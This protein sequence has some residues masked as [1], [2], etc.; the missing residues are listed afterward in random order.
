MD[1]FK[2][3][4]RYALDSPVLAPDFFGFAVRGAFGSTLKK[5][6]CTKHN[7]KSCKNCSLI[8]NCAYGYLYETGKQDP[9]EIK[10]IP[11]TKPYLFRN[12]YL[13]E[14]QLSFELLIFTKRALR[15]SSVLEIALKSL[16]KIGARKNFGYGKIH[17]QSFTKQKITLPEKY[18]LR[19]RLRLTFL[20]PTQIIKEYSLRVQPTLE[21]IIMN[22]ARKY[23][24]IYYNYYNTQS[25]INFRALKR[26]LLAS[27]CLVN[28]TEKVYFTRWSNKRNR[29]EP[30]AAIIGSC[31]YSLPKQLKKNKDFRKLLNFLEYSGTGKRTTAGFGQVKI[32]T[33]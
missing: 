6:S 7:L 1:I 14:N 33:Y 31:T 21:E 12:I 29:R 15:F 30:I 19:D 25:S 11:I 2:I 28:K 5:I 8:N 13:D 3:S 27:R 16:N 10:H 9:L 23:H 18:L 4:V 22:A 32:T 20:S 24:L 17:F 26:D